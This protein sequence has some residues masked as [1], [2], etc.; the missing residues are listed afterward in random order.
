[1]F[2]S[3]DGLLQHAVEL[4][5]ALAGDSW[6]RRDKDHG[7]NGKKATKTAAK[8]IHRTCALA[9]CRPSPTVT[10]K[11]CANPFNYMTLVNNKH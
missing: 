7:D 8:E 1:M 9:R 10:M 3:V 11:E 4:R 2:G 5:T 6:N